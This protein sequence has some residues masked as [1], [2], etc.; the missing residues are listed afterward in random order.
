VPGV[1]LAVSAAPY[2]GAARLLAHGLKYGRR[3]GLAGVAAGAILDACPGDELGGVIVPV[4]AA[5]WRGRWRGFDPAEEIALEISRRAGLGYE[6]CLRRGRGPRQVG[7][8]RRERLADPPRISL[9]DG[10]A[11]PR[12]ALLV[13]DVRTTGATLESCARALRAGGAERVVALVFARSFSRALTPGVRFRLN[14]RKEGAREDRYP[15]SQRRG[16]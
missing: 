15:G 5:P 11:A 3:I 13:D 6:P 4:P 9:R 10:A 2:E 14:P 12:S 1:D 8:A 16:G 7:R